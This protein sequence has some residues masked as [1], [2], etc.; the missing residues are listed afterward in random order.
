MKTGESVRLA[1]PPG[2]LGGVRTVLDAPHISSGSPL[3]PP[4]IPPECHY[5]P[6][7]SQPR[8]PAPLLRARC[9]PPS[10][11]VH[12][13][14][15]SLPCSCISSCSAS[16]SRRRSSPA[17]CLLSL[18]ALWVF[19]S[20]CHRRLLPVPS[21]MTESTIASGGRPRT[22]MSDDAEDGNNAPGTRKGSGALLL[23]ERGHRR[24]EAATMRQG[25]RCGVLMTCSN[26]AL[27]RCG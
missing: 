19:V 18:A 26:G 22:E 13:S 27:A 7:A 4:A 6:A 24:A 9:Q 5:R 8:S 23:L 15:S 21:G 1:A 10:T 3:V 17:Q 25:V 11:H 14:S 16:A 12:S 2:G 20:L